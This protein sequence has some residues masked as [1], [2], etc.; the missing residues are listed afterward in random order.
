[1]G[2]LGEKGDRAV[3][4]NAQ[5]WLPAPSSQWASRWPVGLQEPL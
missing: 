3:Q 5:A 4:G 2:G 1:M